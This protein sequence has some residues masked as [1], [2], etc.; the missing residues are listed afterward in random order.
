MVSGQRKTA[1]RPRTQS[2]FRRGSCCSCTRNGMLARRWQDKVTKSLLSSSPRPAPT[3]L[4]LALAF[5]MLDR[6]SKDLLSWESDL[7]AGSLEEGSRTNAGRL[8]TEASTRNS[9]ASSARDSRSWV[10]SSTR[11]PSLTSAPLI[12]WRPKRNSAICSD[13]YCSDT[14]LTNSAMKRARAAVVP[15]DCTESWWLS[16]SA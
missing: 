3:S 1:H 11:E 6:A 12:V 14:S 10:R 4:A 16:L 13:G 9:C 5:T 15:R 8:V 7:L 2:L